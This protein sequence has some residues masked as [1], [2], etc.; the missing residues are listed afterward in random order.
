MKNNFVTEKILPAFRT[1]NV[2][3]ACSCSNE[4]SPYLGV[5]L[6]S[7][8][9][10]ISPLNNYDIIVFERNITSNCKD[11]LKGMAYPKNVSLR[12][13]NPE[14]LFNGIDLYISHDVFSREC[15]Y[16]ICAPVVLQEYK[17]IIFTDIDIILRDDIAKLFSIDL[18]GKTIGACKEILWEDFYRK[19]RKIK[20]INIREYTRDILKLNHTYDYYN[21]GVVL[22]DVCKYNSEEAFGEILTLI[23]KHKFLYQEQCAVNVFFRDR[24]FNLPLEWNYEL[25][26]QMFR[27]QEIY[28]KDYAAKRCSAY[29]FHYLSG[30]KPW[31]FPDLPLSEVWWALARQTPFYEEII[32]KLFNYNLE[33]REYPTN[34]VD[35]TDSSELLFIIDHLIKFEIKKIWYRI[36]KN[37]G[38][39]YKKQKYQKKYEKIKLLIKE[40][41][42]LKRKLTKI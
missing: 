38:S 12:F 30:L 10:H 35:K 11:K 6:Q 21:T 14:H 1:N 39:E 15:Y 13:F 5:Y 36:K 25:A 19:N 27:P 17:K 42:A 9:E 16:R 40:A 41:K 24:I 7:I 23:K 33:H 29:L 31:F 4:Y 22:I 26:S 18:Q 34:S 28:L 37:R 20:G 8:I 32:V 3:I 2:A